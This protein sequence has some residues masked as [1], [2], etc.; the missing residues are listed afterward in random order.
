MST[1]WQ[2]QDK[3]GKI[4]WWRRQW[5]G[6]CASWVCVCVCVWMWVRVCACVCVCMPLCLSLSLS[7]ALSLP[8]ALSLSRSFFLSLSLSLS[9]AHARSLSVF[10][11]LALCLSATLSPLYLS[12]LLSRSP[13]CSLPFSLSFLIFTHSISLHLLLYECENVHIC[14]HINI[15]IHTYIHTYILTYIYIRIHTYKEEVIRDSFDR[16]SFIQAWHTWLLHMQ[17]PWLITQKD[18]M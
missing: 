1:R 2:G 7:L 9:L 18:Y 4:C 16:D 6:W 10:L 8:L 12:I 11:S 14:I 13:A 3:A 5:R 15:H 17:M